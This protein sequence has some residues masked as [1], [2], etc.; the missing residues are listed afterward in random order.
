MGMGFLCLCMFLF[1]KPIVFLMSTPSYYKSY[2]VVGIVAFSQLIYGCYLIFLPGLYYAK[3][4]GQVNL[5]LF[6]SC[7]INIVLNAILIPKWNMLGAALATVVSFVWMAAMTHFCAK[8]YL[9]VLY[10]W[11]R[12]LRYLVLLGLAATTS[13]VYVGIDLIGQIV[14]ATVVLALFVYLNYFLLNEKDRSYLKQMWHN[15]PALKKMT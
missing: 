1:A 3:K 6:I 14:K 12:I 9:M 5:I 13:F 7:V 2:I 10:D 8:R 11:S 15:I 4:T